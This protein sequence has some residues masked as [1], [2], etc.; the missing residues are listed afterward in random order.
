MSHTAFL[1]IF[2]CECVI[3]RVSCL[4]VSSVYMSG[5]KTR[6]CKE[7]LLQVKQRLIREQENRTKKRVSE[8]LDSRGRDSDSDG[9]EQQDSVFEENLDFPSLIRR[10]LYLGLLCLLLLIVLQTYWFSST[11][12]RA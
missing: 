3:G 8:L 2:T 6:R 10:D 11:C 7:T 9:E 1:E 5:R 12:L 4:V